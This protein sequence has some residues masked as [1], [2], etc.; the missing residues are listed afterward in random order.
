MP[1]S[2][3]PFSPEETT[4]LIEFAR[5]VAAGRR[6]LR[7][8]AWIGTAAIGLAALFYYVIGIRNGMHSK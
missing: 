7:M 1:E 3:F 8:V 6:I 2:Q 4:I 5:S